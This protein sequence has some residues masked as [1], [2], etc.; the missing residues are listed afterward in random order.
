MIQEIHFIGYFQD[1][2]A[3]TAVQ[4]YPALLRCTKCNT[5]HDK[6]FNLNFDN[7]IIENNM[8]Y[9]CI[10]ECKLCHSRMKVNILQPMMQAITAKDS[11]SGEVISCEVDFGSKRERGKYFLVST[12]DCVDCEVID[13]PK[14]DFDLYGGNG[15]LF[16]DVPIEESGWIGTYDDHE[17]VVIDCWEIRIVNKQ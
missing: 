9:N 6:Y 11:E 1:V 12:L 7:K 10:L 14:I 2:D 8:P 17:S 13:I 3:I 5:E 4:T 15:R 16:R